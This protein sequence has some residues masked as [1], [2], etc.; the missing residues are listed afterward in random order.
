MLFESAGTYTA[1][2]ATKRFSVGEERDAIDANSK[3]SA[4]IGKDESF[5]TYLSDGNILVIDGGNVKISMM[6]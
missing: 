2:H 5:S 6:E 1:Y 3:A 4:W